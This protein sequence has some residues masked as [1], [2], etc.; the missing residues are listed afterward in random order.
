ME[1]VPAS[2]PL[3][4]PLDAFT[5]AFV[6]S[7]LLH[8]PLGVASAS[9]VVAWA[10]TVVVPVIAAGEVL[11]TFNEAVTEQ[12]PSVYVNTVV[13]VEVVAV[14]TPVELLMV[15]TVTGALLHVPLPVASVKE[16]YTDNVHT[17]DGA[18]A[19]LMPVMAAGIGFTVTLLVA[20]VPQPVA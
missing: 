15:P 17:A 6:T 4:T 3:T 7:L 11:P 14:N 19:K 9:A 1:T 20:A 13:P 2:T 12:V 16:L 8:T 10:Q 18:G 5:V